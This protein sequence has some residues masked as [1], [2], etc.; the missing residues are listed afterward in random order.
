M[1]LE[2]AAWETNGGRKLSC[3]AR[4]THGFPI[5]DDSAVVWQTSALFPVRT[6]ARK[7]QISG[8]RRLST[9][10]CRTRRITMAAG[11]KERL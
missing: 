4:W 10:L 3:Q 8:G 2:S 1:C 5:K 9:S 7:I 6:A 11:G